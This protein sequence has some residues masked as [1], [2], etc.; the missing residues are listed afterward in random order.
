MSLHAA[1]WR[2]TKEAWKSAFSEKILEYI[3]PVDGCPC[4][5]RKCSSGTLHALCLT[6]PE[7]HGD[8]LREVHG[9]C[10]YLIAAA[11]SSDQDVC[12]GYLGQIRCDHLWGRKRHT[13]VAQ[14]Q[15]GPKLTPHALNMLVNCPWARIPSSVDWENGLHALRLFFFFQ[16]DWPTLKTQYSVVA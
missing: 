16:P 12:R 15:N 5:D 10:V 13:P 7:S 1:R 6:N 14:W 11:S 9:F 2:A 3:C 4:T 8:V